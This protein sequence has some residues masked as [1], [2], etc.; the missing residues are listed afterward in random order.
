MDIQYEKY[1]LNTHQDFVLN[2]FKKLTNKNMKI[3][4]KI[5]IKG[6]AC[7]GVNSIHPCFCSFYVNKTIEKKNKLKEKLTTKNK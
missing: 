6:C 7:Y 4:K 2:V 5:K 1:I 3:N